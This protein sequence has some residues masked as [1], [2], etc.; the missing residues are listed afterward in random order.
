MGRRITVWLPYVLS[1]DLLEL[2]RVV[3]GKGVKVCSYF[4][5]DIEPNDHQGIL[6]FLDSHKDDEHFVYL[7]C[8]THV[9]V[10]TSQSYVCG[11]LEDDQNSRITSVWHNKPRTAHNRNLHVRRVWVS[12]AESFRRRRDGHHEYVH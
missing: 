12:K 4:S 9:G 11:W 2:M 5:K 8:R 7:V 1:K 10:A 3:H 6:D